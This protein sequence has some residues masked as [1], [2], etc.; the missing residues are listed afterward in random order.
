MVFILIMTQ[1]SSGFTA[2]KSWTSY[3]FGKDTLKYK[4]FLQI[5]QNVYLCI[6]SWAIP[7][8]KIKNYN[9]VTGPSLWVR[10]ANSTSWWQSGTVSIWTCVSTQSPSP[11]FQ[12]QVHRIFKIERNSPNFN[13]FN[14]LWTRVILFL[15]KLINSRTNTWIYFFKQLGN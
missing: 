11:K 5:T 15:K 1:L 10:N 8:E 14:Q 2:K 3:S 4:T 7:V 13:I 12:F 6:R 9:L